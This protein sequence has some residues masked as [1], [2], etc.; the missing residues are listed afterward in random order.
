MTRRPLPWTRRSRTPSTTL[1]LPPTWCAAPRN[2]RPGCA[3]TGWRPSSRPPSPTSSPPPTVR[4]SSSWSPNSRGCAPTT[5]SSARRAPP[6]TAPRGARGSSIPSTART[7]SRPAPTTGV[8]PSPWSRVPRTI[9][10][11]SSSA[12][13]IGRRKASR[14]S[15]ARTCRRRAPMS[16]GPSNWS[17][18]ATRRP[19]RSAWARTC[20]RHGL[21]TA[22]W[23]RPGSKRRGD[24][25]RGACSARRRW[26]W[27]GSPTGASGRGSSI[28]WRRG[29]GCPAMPWSPESAA[30]ARWSTAG[31]SRAPRTSW[32]SSRKR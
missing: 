13:C 11:G 14:G 20:T 30:P 1:R 5:A 18:S 7:T 3:R 12:R 29:I 26:I 6:R 8:R 25:P 32:P 4:R 28:R 24:S 22:P 23:W 10:S 2:S 16:A 15:A 31:A 21:A 9:R 17:A 19:A 27:P